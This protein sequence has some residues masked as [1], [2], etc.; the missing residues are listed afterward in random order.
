MDQHVFPNGAHNMVSENSVLPLP[1][2]DLPD[3]LSF[4]EAI[5]G[6]AGSGALLLDPATGDCLFADDNVERQLGYSVEEIKQG[7]ADFLLGLL[8]PEDSGL[9]RRD[10]ELRVR[11]RNGDWRW[12]RLKRSRIQS[13]H[14]GG[15]RRVL[16]VFQEVTGLRENEEHVCLN[17]R[18]FKE[19]K[20]VQER[21]QRSEALLIEAQ[22]LAGLG[23]FE[24]DLR[25]GSH[26]WSEGMYRLLHLDPKKG[27]MD[28][29]SFLA[30][31]PPGDRDHWTLACTRR[32]H[33]KGLLRSEFKLEIEDGSVRHLVMLARLATSASGWPER[34][35]G[36]IQDVTVRRKDEE[37]RK[38]FQER[39]HRSEKMEAVGQLAGG[40]AHDFN[41]HLAAIMGFAGLLRD[42]LEAEHPELHRYATNIIT[43]CRRSSE[44]T[45]QLLAFARKGKYLTVPVDLQEIIEEVIQILRHSID[46]RILVKRV[47][48]GQSAVVLGDPSLL[49]NALLNLA[50]N[51]R[52]A[53]PEGGTLTFATEARELEEDYCK[54]LPYDVRPGPYL[55]VS[56]TDTGIGMD[57]ELQLH[58]FEPFFTTKERGKG[59]GLGLASVYGTVKSHHGT[60]LVN[61]EPGEGSCFK[62]YLPLAN[63]ASS[64]P[65]WDTRDLPEAQ[66]LDVDP[67]SKCVLVVEDEDLVAQ[68]LVAQ[69]EDMG[70]KT[71]LACDGLA[72]VDF[73]REASHHI[74]LVILDMVMPQMSGRDAF[75]ALRA[76]Q[77]DVKIVLSSG[78]SLSGDAQTILEQGA[79]GFLQKPYQT[80]ELARVLA[81]AFAG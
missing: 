76:I 45:Q 80:R 32:V 81:Q 57:K 18:E 33:G 61:S 64:G 19:L 38:W 68:V 37:D 41:N 72:A 67:P 51:A 30:M 75:H 22:R 79:L 3:R 69:L 15:P 24:Q 1:G 47:S 8:H 31:L 36:A 25:A 54:E 27:P 14:T 40:I 6:V 20:H 44:L 16:V 43:S 55:Q 13:A 42:R 11:H 28:L 17:A 26:T 66:I 74:D 60:I 7:G 4:L 5:H 9:P 29:D 50:I 53:M 70:F 63:A 2:D 46:R 34:L 48:D 10:A 71:L 39:I 52:D 78:Y 12:F 59:T 49:Q 56:V 21:L 77:P 23:S 62:I 73:F 35:L 58:I 65:G